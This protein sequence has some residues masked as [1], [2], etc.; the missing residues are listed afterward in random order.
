V[1]ASLHEL[2][3]AYTPTAFPFLIVFPICLALY[4]RNVLPLPLFLPGVAVLCVVLSAW[5]LFVVCLPEHRALLFAQLRHW[6]RAK[7]D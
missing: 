3:Q 1:P 2:F 6:V 7:G 4:D 5:G